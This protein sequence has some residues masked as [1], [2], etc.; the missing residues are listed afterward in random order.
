[1]SSGRD[2]GGYSVT[3]R[4]GTAFGVLIGLILLVAG[5]VLTGAFIGHATSDVIV[6]R[7]QPAL[8]D[9]LRLHR[10][11]ADIQRSMRGYL[12]TGD[13]K[14]LDAYRSAREAYPAILATAL[15]HG[16][17]ETDQNLRTQARQLQAYLRITE[18]QEK[19][20]PRS[21]QAAQL[22]R[23][24]N[25]PYSAFEATN[26]ELE[27]QLTKEARRLD[28]RSDRIVRV[29]FA[30][31]G[32]LLI[33]A[34]ATAVYT[35]LRTTR[36]L[37]RPL[38]GVERTLGRLTAGEH[39][40][41]AKEQ[42]PAEIRAV[43]RSVNTL[44]DESDRLRRIEEE[45]G[46]LSKTARDV[47]IRIRERL[48]VDQVLDVTCTGMGEG[49]DADYAFVLLSDGDKPTVPVS[50]AWSADQGLLPTEEQRALP[51]VP[52][53]VIR[54]HYRRGTTWT[55]DDLS[56]YL[57]ETTPL[58]G[59][60]GSFGKT[61]MPEENRDAAASL[62]LVSVVLIPL[63][64]GEEP[65]GAVAL[66]R[67]RPGHRWRAVEIE[68]AESM[69]AGVGRALHNS[70]LYGQEARLVEKL[71]ALDQ[72]KSDF[73]STVSHELRTPLTSIVGYIELLKDDDT[74]PLAEPQRRMLDIVDRNANRLRALIE[75]LL[76]LSRIEAGTFSSQKSEIDLRRLVTSAVDTIK[77]A[78]EAGSV[79]LEID[80][81]EVPLVL[82][83]D[84][85]QL[86]RVLMN[87]LSNAVKFTP[88]GGLVRVEAAA[89]DGHAVLSVSDT[90]IGIPEEERKQL[91]SRFFRASNAVDAAIPGTGLGLTIVNT[92]VTNHGGTTEVHSQEGEGTTVT[93]RLP[94]VAA[95]EVVQATP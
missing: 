29:S 38:K 88:S 50:R 87:L 76:T 45:R 56:D 49:L 26:H 25:V 80:C 93:A 94:L 19:A 36:A 14:Q 17:P 41:R 72:A 75:D 20:R 21:E 53:E 46:Q 91:F 60:P 51:P 39:S 84:S 12:I 37:A 7:L 55:I 4:L 9:N 47:G 40:A 48:D 52:A 23:K 6:D 31:V 35:S 85:D 69:V 13:Q 95:P 73:L 77:P 90:G 65:M 5:G 92:I 70:M 78:A 44:A 28:H 82:E 10:E 3:R 30:G 59:A 2:R 89:D 15:R 54:D 71:R 1:M 79:R 18:Q 33:A 58:P 83:A 86:D 64:V 22:T 81:P 34:L 68:I 16:D 24:A 8:I 42:G 57:A 63:G 61:G 43:A 67:T 27:V 62:G 66:A 11:A 74:G 32:A